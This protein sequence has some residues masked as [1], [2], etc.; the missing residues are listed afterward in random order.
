ML[1]LQSF[2][3][4]YLL[5][6]YCNVHAD[7]RYQLADW[8]Q[9]PLSREMLQYAR[10]D[11]HYLLFVYDKMRQELVE[12]ALKT[13]ADPREMIKSVLK[14]SAE[15][16][17]KRFVKPV[18]K[19]YGYHAIAAKHKIMLSSKKYNALLRIMQW[20]DLVAREEDVS[21]GYVM[22]NVVMF[23][24]VNA[25]PLNSETELNLQFNKM[26]SD[27]AKAR[28]AQLLEIIKLD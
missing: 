9:R 28:K 1:Q 17:L 18:L 23:K 27:F 8:T 26:L 6:K 15:I 25:L 10:E 16:C 12:K 24:I 2:G 4:A 13:S 19:D 3:L 5:Q 14:K 20:R 22:E 7:K 11:T 21:T